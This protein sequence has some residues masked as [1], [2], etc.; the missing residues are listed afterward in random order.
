MRHWRLPLLRRRDL[1]R[2]VVL[3]TGKGTDLRT[4]NRW[5]LCQIQK[6]HIRFLAET[7]RHVDV[8]VP[9]GVVLYFMVGKGFS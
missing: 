2:G 9:G 5:L 6:P 1:T 3:N 8:C 4:R 7:E